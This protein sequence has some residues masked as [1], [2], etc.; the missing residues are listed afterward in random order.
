MA[1]PRAKAAKPKYEPIRPEFNQADYVADILTR[2]LV[3]MQKRCAI[4]EAAV[5]ERDG[6]INANAEVLGLQVQSVEPHTHE[7]QV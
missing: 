2:Q 3:E 4:L 6:F 5:A 1:Q 7:E